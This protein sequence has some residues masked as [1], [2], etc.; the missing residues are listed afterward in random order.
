MRSP[1]KPRVRGPEAPGGPARPGP[2]LAPL[3]ALVF[4]LVSAWCAMGI[5]VQATRYAQ[6]TADEP[7]YLLSAISLAEDHDLDISDELAERRWL[8]FHKPLLPEQ[9]KPLPGG[10]RLSPHDPLLPLLLAVP[11]ALGGW[12][13]AKL[14]LAALAGLLA[15]LLVWT[16]V[17]RFGARPGPVVVAV[18]ACALSPPLAVYATQVY[19]ELPAALAVTIG[20]AALTARPLRARHLAAAALAVVALPWLGVK[21]A[22]VAAV[23][24]LGAA[25]PLV[26]GRRWAALA[27][28]GGGLAVAGVAYVLGHEAI[29]GGLTPYAVGD[30]FVGGEFEVVGTRPNYLGRSIRLTALLTDRGF[31]LIGWAPVWLVAVAA[32]AALARRRPA[33]SPVLGGTLAAGWL[34]ATFV[35]LTMQGWWWPGRQVVVVLPAAVLALAWWAGTVAGRRGV[36]VTGL[37]GLAGAAT[38][39]QV[40]AEGRAHRLNWVVDFATTHAPVHRALSPLLPDW[41]HPDPS[42]WPLHAAWLAVLAVVAWAGWRSARA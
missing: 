33:G 11:V 10:Q 34:T 4:A 20:L 14:A 27:W 15:A 19:P 30:H 18:L 3:L 36:L 25:W 22:P 42:S 23:L 26:R 16:A 2:R 7:Q 38:F 29:Y 12:V 6:V 17:R 1:E 28:L 40:A 24:A 35:A 21:Y 31:G 41:L 9:T 39:A 37:A 5:P 8:A 32:L 13:G